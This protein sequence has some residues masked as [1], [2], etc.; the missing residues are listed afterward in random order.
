[1]KFCFDAQSEDAV[2]ELLQN[3]ADMDITFQALKVKV[4]FTGWRTMKQPVLK[5]EV[6]NQMNYSCIY[7]FSVK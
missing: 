4:R 3:L 5:Q 6:F 7:Y 1:M 2:V